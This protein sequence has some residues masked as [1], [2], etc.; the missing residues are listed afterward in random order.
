MRVP[1]PAAMMTTFNAMCSS[2]FKRCQR[3][4][5]IGLTTTLLAALLGGCSALRLAYDQGPTVARWWL[6]GY[7]DIRDAQQ[8]L[9]RQAISTWFDWHRR[10]QLPDYVQ[11]LDRAQREVTEPVHADQLCRWA[12]DLRGRYEVAVEQALPLVADAVRTLDARQVDHLETKYAK[13]NADYRKEFLQSKPED[14][15][16]ASLERTIDRAQTLYGRLEPSQKRLLATQLKAAPFDAQAWYRQR[17]AQQQDIVKTLRQIV[18]DR[19]DRERTMAL[20]KGL[21]ERWITSRRGDAPAYEQRLLQANC[22]LVAQLHNA[23]SPSQRQHARDKL[24]GWEE[25][26]RALV[27]E[28]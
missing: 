24:K 28:R 18:A 26:L 15:F 16:E 20:L 9:V 27:R 5:I 6:D 23:T 14:R 1:L 12:E 13:K 25:D 17:V 19:P 2:F 7:L 8:P 10:T 4:L 21:K 22:D 11:L 3:A